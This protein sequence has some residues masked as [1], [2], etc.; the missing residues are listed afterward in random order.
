MTA[1]GEWRLTLESEQPLQV[2]SLLSGPSGHLSNLSTAPV[3]VPKTLPPVFR[4]DDP[5]TPGAQTPEDVFRT[6]VSPIVQAKCIFCHRAGGFPADMPNSRLQFNPATVEGH[7]ELNQAVFEALIAILG[8]DEDVDDPVTYILNKVQGVGHGGGVQTAAGTAD[9]ASLER[10]LGLLGEAVAP[11][12]ITPETLF[13]GVRMESTRQTL[14]RAAIV[15]AGRVPTDAEYAAIEG[16]GEDEEAGEEALRATIRGLMTGP[17]FHEFLIRASNDRLFT[18]RDGTIIDDGSTDEFVDLT[19]LGY[20]NAMTLSHEKYRRWKDEVQYGMRRAPLELI[21]HVA[22]N[23]LPYTEV[24][25]ADY[26]MANPLAAQ[27]YG[28]STEFDDESDVHEFRPSEIV[29]YYRDDES[30]VTENTQFGMHVLDPGNLATDYPHAGILNTT[31]FLLRYPTTATNRNRAR[32]RWTYYHFLGLDIEKSASRTT[33]PLALADTNN[34]TFNNPACTVCHTVLDPVAGAFQNYAD[35]G[36]YRLYGFD[37]LDDQYRNGDLRKIY[38]DAAT[39]QSRQIVSEAVWLDPGSSLAISHPQNNGCGVAG[40]ET[41]GRDLRIEDFQIRD[42]QGQIVDHIEWSEIDDHCRSD[43]ASNDGSSGDDDHY[44]WWG[45]ECNQIPVQIPEAGNY[46]LRMTVWADQSGEEITWFELGASLYQEEDTWYRD[47]RK[48]GFGGAMAPESENSVQWLAQQIVADERFAEATVKF[49]WPAIMGNEVAEPPEDETETDFAGLLLASNALAAAV[50]RLADGF[51]SGSKGGSSYNLK[52][53]LVEMALS[54]WFRVDSITVNDP[55]R[56]T[57]LANAGARRLLTPEELA[58]K[59]LAVTGFRWGR[60]PEQNWRP[61]HKRQWSDLSDIEN[62]YGLLYGGID[63]DGITERARDFTSVMAGVA[64]SH[65]LQSSH[66]I[67]MREFFLLPDEDRLLF[68]GVDKNVSP[69]FEFGRTFAITADSSANRMSLTLHGRLSVG[70]KTVSLTFLNDFSQS[71]PQADRNI[72]LDRIDVLNGTDALVAT[73]ELEDIEADQ[74]HCNR[75]VGDH[76]ALYCSGSVQVPFTV[77]ADDDYTVEVVAWA[78]HAGDELPM[79]DISF[80]SDTGNSEGANRIR[81]KLVELYDKLHGI[82]V[83]ADSPEVSEAYELFVEVWERKRGK[84]GNNHFLRKGEE[85]IRNDWWGDAHFLDGIVDDHSR[86]EIDE[87]TNELG[88]AGWDWDR[89]DEFFDNIDWS[90]PQAVAK[91]WTVVLAYLMMDYRYLY[92]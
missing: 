41:C 66:P 46:V 85:N 89:I 42:L 84:D 20:H 12:G 23:D 8:E 51:R 22:E 2:M 79:L 29:S 76:F 40:N 6:E 17:G 88:W 83:T 52:D 53:L 25:T 64:Q 65:A 68:A 7:V 63:S 54:K 4:T 34:P 14:R 18:D 48:P 37:S 10:F 71:E 31:V 47:M 39:Y 28:A 43:G 16:V 62:G 19:N 5:E 9:Y 30:K 49:W 58:N 92:L 61:P 21:A 73:I 75:P 80:H 24:L 90:D 38:V 72:R 67:I 45:W 86:V 77:P 1:T 57:A 82:E 91:T 33:D 36:F 78:D 44:Q 60:K 50:T 32:S 81:G 35:E 56:R 11:V 26:I 3:L 13:E 70:G 15:F 87:E 69:T 55:V 59:T 74:Q 27:A